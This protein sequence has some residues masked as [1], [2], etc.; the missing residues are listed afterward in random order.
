[1]KLQKSTMAEAFDV[2]PGIVLPV[3]EA[4]GR[5]ASM[6]EVNDPN[7]SLTFHASQMNVVLHF[8]LNIELEWAREQFEALVRFAQR[9]PCRIIVLCPSSADLGSSMESKLFSQ[10]YIGESHREMCCCEALI[11]RYNPLDSESLFNHL[12]I[13]LEG[14]LPTYSWFSDVPTERFESHLEAMQK[15]GVRRCVFNR[16]DELNELTAL[17]WPDE[18]QISD[19]AEAF[20]LPVR[21]I[22]G[23][24]LSRYPVDV[25]CEG[26]K[27]VRVRYSG[28]SGESCA[29]IEWVKSCL[30]E[31]GKRRVD[32]VFQPEFVSEE[33]EPN[34]DY[35]L[36]MKFT[37]DNEKYFVFGRSDDDLKSELSANFGGS[38]EFVCVPIKPLKLEQ[39][40]AEA[41]FAS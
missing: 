12:S 2:L 4:T 35:S 27:A 41:F 13:W 31:C 19:L 29:L 36:E 5:L 37:Y 24:F 20:L 23:Q 6:W 40:L 15:L 25:I 9:Y 39:A 18:Y 38:D 16:S 33:I 32:I 28:V 22:I 26:L 30:N 21:Q 8:G 11:L 14:D 1:L 7:F 3:R 10:C 17:D 34:S